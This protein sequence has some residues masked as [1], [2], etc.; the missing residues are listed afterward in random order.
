[1]PATVAHT[2]MVMLSCRP[3]MMSSA[4]DEKLGLQEA[5]DEARAAA[6]PFG[7]PCPVHVDRAQRQHEVE[8]APR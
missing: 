3:I 7:Q 1:M 6:Q 4:R 8:Q 5:L 2:V